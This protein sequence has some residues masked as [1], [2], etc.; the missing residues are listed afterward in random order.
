M[1]MSDDELGALA[2]DDTDEERK[3]DDAPVAAVSRD[4]L[5]LRASLPIRLGGVGLRPVSRSMLAAYYSALVAA[6]PELLRICA[7]MRLADG[8]T[9]LTHPAAIELQLACAPR[10]ST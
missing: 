4:Q 8:A 2:Q 6:L 9:A 5:L 3:S 1:R 7:D 10:A